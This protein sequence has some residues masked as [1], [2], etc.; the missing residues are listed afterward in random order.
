[1][2]KKNTSV[3]YNGLIWGLILGFVGIIYNVI[4]YMFDQNLNQALGYAAMLLSLV[5]MIF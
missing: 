5:V 1:M 3:L 2:E 4:L